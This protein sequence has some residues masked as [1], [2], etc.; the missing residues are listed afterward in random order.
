MFPN[1]NKDDDLNN[2]MANDKKVTLHRYT[3]KMVGKEV[4][5]SY[6]TILMLNSIYIRH[7]KARMDMFLLCMLPKQF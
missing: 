5:C 6:E 2:Y 7:L 3:E 1:S 4:P